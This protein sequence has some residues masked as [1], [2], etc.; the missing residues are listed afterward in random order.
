[1]VD[2]RWFRATE[3]LLV[4]DDACSIH[5]SDHP[6]ITDL[7]LSKCLEPNL[8]GTVGKLRDS[9]SGASSEDQDAGLTSTGAEDGPIDV[10][11]ADETSLEDVVGFR[12]IISLGDGALHPVEFADDCWWQWRESAG[13]QTLNLLRGLVPIGSA[14]TTL[15]GD[16]GNDCE[17]QPR[18]AA[19][20]I[21]G[22]GGGR[23]MGP[24][25]DVSTVERILPV[26]AWQ[27]PLVDGTEAA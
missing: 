5:G 20:P 24:C 12:R 25:Y 7:P 17:E 8:V 14:G 18:W 21:L 6:R 1:M 22:Q 10:S 2:R 3:R 16:R 27:S 11:L 19:G 26:D 23:N 13:R 15:A 9:F 4:S